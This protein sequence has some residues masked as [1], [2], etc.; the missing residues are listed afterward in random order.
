PSDNLPSVPGVGEK[1]AAKWI[2]EHGSLA[3]LLENMDEIKGKVGESLRANVDAVRLN[4]RLTELDRGVELDRGPG[5]LER[6]SGDAEAVDR[7]FETLQFRVLRP[8]VA[9]V[10][11]LDGEAAA[12]EAESAPPIEVDGRVLGT[13]EVAA[14]L[15]EHA[16]GDGLL[17]IALTGRWG[18]GGGDVTA[19]AIATGSGPAAWVNPTE[20][21]PSDEQALRGYLGDA[22]KP[23]ALHDAKGPLL[24]LDARGLSLAGLAADT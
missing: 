13:G 7:L 16:G 9:E 2:R 20:L 22:A 14:W 3:A 6:A 18:R 5:D 4:R 21:D 1:T 8:R 23:K 15:A 24:A 10:F 12:D 19:L 11:G 17:G